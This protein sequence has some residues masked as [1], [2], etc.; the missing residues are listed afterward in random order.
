MTLDSLITRGGDTL[1]FMTYRGVITPITRTVPSDVANSNVTIGGTSAGVLIW[2]TMWDAY[3]S[4]STHTRLT[5][6]VRVFVY[7]E[8][9]MTVLALDSDIVSRF[10]VRP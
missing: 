8:E 10:Q 5:M 3:V 2:S 1:A 7:G 9:P 6:R 4:G